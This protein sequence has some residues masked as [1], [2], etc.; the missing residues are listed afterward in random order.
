[1]GKGRLEAFSDGVF[2][3]II[4]LMALEI[5]VPQG[6][7]LVAL[8]AMYPVL[9]D[10]ILSF[11]YIGIYWNNHHHLLHLVEKVDG[12]VMWA[13]L[14]LLFWLSLVPVATAWADEH[15][16]RSIPVALYGS[17]LMLSGFAYRLLVMAILRIHGPD[18][19]IARAVG[20]DFKGKISLV[21]YT[22][23]IGLAFV[24]PIIGDFFY[25]VV[26]VLW[27]VPDRRITKTVTEQ[28]H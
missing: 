8:Q 4:T 6:S 22:V 2:A 28:H 12:R 19:A 17:F 18:S 27:I 25:V 20:S 3:V 21:L 1:M 16:S 13:N 14:H 11:T 26:A 15:P 9:L 10:H 23:G 5:K 7:D 24:H